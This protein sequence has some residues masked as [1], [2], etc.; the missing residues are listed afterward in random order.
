MFFFLAWHVRLSQY[1]TETT[2][3]PSEKEQASTAVAE[4][5]RLMALQASSGLALADSG[6]EKENSSAEA[7]PP[8][9]ALSALS[10]PSKP[11]NPAA[12]RKRILSSTSGSESEDEDDVR[13]SGMPPDPDWN[14][15]GNLNTMGLQS[16]YLR[17]RDLG[18]IK[19]FT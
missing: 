3:I 15:P 4:K 5:S 16:S 11:K 14:E 10:S 13:K 2:V 7:K 12:P 1:Y 17:I 8:R 9:P 19:I 18:K 6:S